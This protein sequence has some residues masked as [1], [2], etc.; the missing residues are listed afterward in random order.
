MQGWVAP[1]LLDDAVSLQQLCPDL[2]KRV[3]KAVAKLGFVYPTLVQV[4]VVGSRVCDVR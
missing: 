3:L 1:S 2:D 4:R